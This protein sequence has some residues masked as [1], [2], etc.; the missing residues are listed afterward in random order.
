MLG[1]YWG[2]YLKFRPEIVTQ[3]LTTLFRWA[4]EGR[5]KPHI[6]HVLPLER[7]QEGLDLLKTRASTGKVVI[8]L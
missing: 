2:G 5:I 1:F 3:S 6:S 7:A 8:T 4:V